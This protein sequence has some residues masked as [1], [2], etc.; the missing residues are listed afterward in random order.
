MCNNVP[1]LFSHRNDFFSL[2]FS[3]FLHEP[4]RQIM[5]KLLLLIVISLLTRTITFSVLFS[6]FFFYILTVLRKYVVLC[7]NVYV[8][9]MQVREHCLFFI[10]FC[11][12]LLCALR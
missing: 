11:S 4:F 12:P 7:Y 6:F 8:V 1:L 2:F 3:Q 10:F 9:L 5:V